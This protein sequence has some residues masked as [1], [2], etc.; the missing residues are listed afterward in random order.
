MFLKHSQQALTEDSSGSGLGL[1]T[2]GR[3]VMET[4]QNSP[5]GP[6]ILGESGDVGEGRE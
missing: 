4:A 3:A 5:Q 1:D 2:A 6:H